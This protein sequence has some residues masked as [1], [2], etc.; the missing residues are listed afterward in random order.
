MP[1]SDSLNAGLAF[2]AGL[3]SFLSPCVLPL[4]P[5]YIGYLS[6]AAVAGR[7]PSRLVTASHAGA[8][9][10]GF[11]SVFVLLGCLAGLAGSL[12]ATRSEPLGLLGR[13]LAGLDHATPWLARLGGLV[14]IVLGVH[15]TGLVRI[16]LLY[17]EF[18]LGGSQPRRGGLV[19]SALVGMIF[20]AGWTPCVGPY[21]M[22]ILM[23]AGSAGTVGRGAALLAAYS[24][25]LGVPFLLAGF[26]LEAVSAHLRRL[27]RY[28]NA[29]SI[30]GGV[31]LV[32]MGLLLVTDRFYW[33]NSLL[34]GLW[35]SPLG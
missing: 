32:A 27:N 11:G 6:G 4:V 31:L 2:V 14:L 7:A 21:L 28:L 5:A 12:V 9:V 24:V 1:A 13:L 18:R 8:F 30:V 3:L 35:Q 33:L 16:P 10:V 17:R 20:A 29:V 23:L 19:T 26:A 15:L 22:A 25:G 34:G